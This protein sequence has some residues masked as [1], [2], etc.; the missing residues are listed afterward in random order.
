MLTPEERMSV[1]VVLYRPEWA[2]MFETLK[3][4]VSEALDGIDFRIE[5]VG[6]TAVPGLAAKPVID[7]DVILT[8]WEEFEEVAA[9]LESPGFQRRGD[10]GIPWREAFTRSPRFAFAHNL[11][12]CRDGM[13]AVE[14]HLKLRDYLRTHRYD[15]ERYSAR[16][17]ELA[18][19]HPGDIDAYCRGKTEL[20][21]EFLAAAGMDEASIS[22]IEAVNLL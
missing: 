19:L 6:S 11:Y 21:A 3:Q 10:L 12:V 22:E 20:I 7:I 18:A 2:E 16:K 8:R 15:A 13:P 4:A 1:E 14:N 9:R 17:F 5:H